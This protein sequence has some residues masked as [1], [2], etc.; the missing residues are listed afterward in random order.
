MVKAMITWFSSPGRAW[1]LLM[2]HWQNVVQGGDTTQTL[3]GFKE[4]HKS[5]VCYS[6]QVLKLFPSSQTFTGGPRSLRLNSQL[7]VNEA[8]QVDCSVS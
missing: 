6:Y 2:F 8:W 5:Q 7:Q 4:R 3:L 1:K